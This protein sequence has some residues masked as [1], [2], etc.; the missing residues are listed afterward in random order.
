M[1]PEASTRI[2]LEQFLP[3]IFYLITSRL[4]QR[5]L[6]RLRPHGMTV[7]R[8]RVLMVIANKGPSSIGK[9]VELTFIPQSGVSR[10]IDQMERDKLVVRRNSPEDQRVVEVHLSTRG[11]S[12]YRRLAH[13]AVSYADAVVSDFSRRERAELFAMLSRVLSN[14]QSEPKN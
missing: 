10:V 12:I 4:S 9:L 11:K 6:E 5:F 8:W 3:Y 2:E 1:P 13:V 7:P 14:L